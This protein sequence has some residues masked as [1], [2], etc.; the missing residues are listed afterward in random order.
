MSLR[1]NIL[2]L[3]L[4]LGFGIVQPSAQ[5]PL[6]MAMR[7]KLGH[8]Q[9][10]LADVI[11]ADYEGI[12]RNAAPLSRISETEI[13]SWQAR[14][15]PDYTRNAVLFLESVEGIRHA[16]VSKD[17]EAA[18]LEYVSLISSCIRCH[19]YVKEGR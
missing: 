18:R 5:T 1:L 6:Q 10:L 2:V 14:A 3:G 8:A 13:A 7:E 11:T 17:I 4:V 9:R 16:A 15:N 19:A 12:Y